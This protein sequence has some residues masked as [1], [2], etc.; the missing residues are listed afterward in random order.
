MKREW[1]FK[2]V[3]VAD[4]TLGAVG[5]SIIRYIAQAGAEVIHIE[6]RTRPEVCRCA[7]P[8]KDGVTNPEYCSFYTNY[9]NSKHFIALNLSEPKA[10]DIAWKIIMWADVVA[11]SFI[12]GVMKRWG[13]D[14]ESVKK[15]KP[16]IVYLS[17]CLQGQDGPHSNFRGYG[18]HGM[19]LCGFNHLTGSPETEP[20]AIYGAYTDYV[21]PRL[22]GAVLIAALDYKNRTGKGQYIDVSQFE[23]GVEY[24][25]PVVMDYKVNNRLQTRNWNRVPDSAPHNA[26]KCF[27]NEKDRE[28]GKEGWVA[29]AVTK[30]DEWKAFCKVI[31]EP[32]WT[33]E[34][35]FQTLLGRK[36]NENELNE[37]VEK[38]TI[39]F[40]AFE[41]MTLMQEAG[42]PAGVIEDYEDLEKDPQMI[43]RD[44]F[45]YFETHP[46]IGRIMHDGPPFKL[47]KTPSEV[48]FEAGTYGQDT[49]YICKNILKMSE[50]EIADCM[51]QGIFE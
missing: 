51:A 44:H 40:S 21:T 45:V 6:S 24:L 35:K 36:K 38:W 14:Y 2:D 27:V 33:K 37:L 17:T 50:Q 29:I 49:E 22:G 3:K 12:P 34:Q 46:Y 9:Q 15:V 5:T 16:E 43:H 23:C 28:K 39:N 31:G 19:A 30:D 26:Y 4:F 47:S 42:V 10:I 25:A 20:G 32:V 18:T 1:P 7:G 48:R 41:V 8:F 13:I 11:E